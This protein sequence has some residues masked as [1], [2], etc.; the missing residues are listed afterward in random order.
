MV[1]IACPRELRACVSAIQDTGGSTDSCT[2]RGSGAEPVGPVA[3]IQISS[4][5]RTPGATQQW[6]AT[7]PADCEQGSAFFRWCRPLPKPPRLGCGEAQVRVPDEPRK[8]SRSPR[9]GSPRRGLR[10]SCAFECRGVASSDDENSG[11]P[12]ERSYFRSRDARTRFRRPRD[13]STAARSRVTRRARRRAPR[14]RRR[15]GAHGGGVP[16]TRGPASAAP[17]RSNPPGD[18]DTRH[19]SPPRAARRP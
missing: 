17:S 7:V 1:R 6:P 19:G 10:F 4:A 12:A 13:G 18:G 8:V 14:P 16:R 5:K 11:R 2:G 9:S 3:E 15:D